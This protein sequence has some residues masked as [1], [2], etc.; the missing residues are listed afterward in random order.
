MMTEPKTMV[1]TPEQFEALKVILNEHLEHDCEPRLD[2][3]RGCDLEEARKFEAAWDIVFKFM[4]EH[5]LLIPLDASYF[6]TVPDDE[7]ERIANLMAKP[8]FDF[9]KVD[10]LLGHLNTH[11]QAT[12]AQ[13]AAEIVEENKAGFDDKA[14][15]DAVFALGL[16]IAAGEDD[17]EDDDDDDNDDNI[18]IDIDDD[19]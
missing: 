2:H 3:F 15:A 6:A 10:T 13:L 8:G 12:V 5:G 16:M 17:D 14:Y 18:D 4:K 19:E 7:M 11:D 9:S 1:A